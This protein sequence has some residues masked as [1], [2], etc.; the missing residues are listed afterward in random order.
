MD[1]GIG[2]IVRDT[3]FSS[4]RLSELVL[5]ALQIP[6]ERAQQA[7]A[8]FRQHDERLLAETH[9]IYRD[10]KALIQTTQQAAT[11]LEGLFE[12]DRPADAGSQRSP[13]D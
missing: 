7:I 9:A 11:E 2:G 1:R 5:E 12:A 3:F 13:G 4:L 6:G 8:L 10:E